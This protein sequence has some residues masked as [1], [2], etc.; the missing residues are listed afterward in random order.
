[1]ITTYHF[2]WTLMDNCF[3]GSHTTSIFF[4]IGVQKK[5]DNNKWH[6]IHL[7]QQLIHGTKLRGVKPVKPQKNYTNISVKVNKKKNA[8]NN[9][10]DTN[11]KKK[12]YC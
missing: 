12:E 11:S 5:T 4:H 1:M 7:L 6:F 8:V 10:M 9:M 3:I 2:I